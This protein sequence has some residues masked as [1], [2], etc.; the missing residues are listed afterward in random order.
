M[1]YLKRY[2]QK[3]ENGETEVGYKEFMTFLEVA[4]DNGTDNAEEYFL[5]QPLKGKGEE[6]QTYLKKFTRTAE[7][8]KVVEAYKEFPTYYDLLQEEDFEE[9]ERYF[10]LYPLPETPEESRTYNV[11]KDMKEAAE[12]GENIF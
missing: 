10:Q 1:G 11:I 4:A 5:L 9:H 12:R 2:K 6:E 3:K 7:S 8:G